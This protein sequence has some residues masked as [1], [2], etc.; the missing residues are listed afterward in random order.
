MQ[1]QLCGLPRGYNH[2][3]HLSNQEFSFQ[4]MRSVCAKSSSSCCSASARMLLCA[5]RR[6]R[7]T[8]FCFCVQLSKLVCFGNRPSCV[9]TPHFAL[10]FAASAS[11]LVASS[12]NAVSTAPDG[13]CT[14]RTTEPRMNMSF[15]EH[16]NQ[17][18]AHVPIAVH[19]LVHS[20][21][22]VLTIVTRIS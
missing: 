11:L 16:C 21:V 18:L 8:L 7:R 12:S 3:H 9:M 4:K 2:N 6:M 19:S 10:F 14:Y 13:K 20:H 15:V 1:L 17:P 22:V 5:S